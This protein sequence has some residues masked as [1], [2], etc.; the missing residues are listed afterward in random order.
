MY[1]REKA[2]AY[3]DRWWNSANPAYPTFAVDCTNYISQCLRAGGGETWGY[4]DRSKGWW[5]R[6]GTWSFSWSVAHSFRWYLGTSKRGLHAVER[7]AATELEL[8]D[9]ICYDFAGDGRFDHSTIITGF[10]DGEPLVNAH[11][12]SSY[13]RDWRYKTSPAFEDATT[14]KFFHIIS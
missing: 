7:Q 9:V 6:G 8:G 13:H 10:R 1:D 4:P 2:V 14:Y 12:A 5:N 3:A 11:T